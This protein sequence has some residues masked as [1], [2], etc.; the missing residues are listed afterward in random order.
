MW[1]KNLKMPER[2]NRNISMRMAVGEFYSRV[3]RIL[4]VIVSNME[5]LRIDLGICLHWVLPS[6]CS[7][8]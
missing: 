5:N 1:F 3:N 4:L 7:I 2:T 6:T 8:D